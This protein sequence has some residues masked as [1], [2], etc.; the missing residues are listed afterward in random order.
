MGD[1][2][3]TS[4]QFTIATP[5]R[6]ALPKL[7]RCIGSVRGQ[8]E[9][10]YEHLVQDACSDDG[11]SGWLAAEEGGPLSFRSESDTGMYDAINRAWSRS[12]GD[13]LAWL[14]ADE[15]Y[16]PGT[17][18]RVNA[19]FVAHPAVD[20]V[21][22]NY[23]VAGES[24]RPVALRREVPFRRCYVANSFLYAQSC[25]LFFRRRAFDRI[26]LRLDTR[27][28]YASDMDLLLRLADDGAVIHHIP[29]YLSVFG[30]DG[31]N[32]ST[33]PQAAAE[34]EAIRRLHGGAR[35]QA[36]RSL[37]L[38][39]RRVERFVA[40]SYRRE[41]IQFNFA[42]NE[43]PQYTTIEADALGGRYAQSDFEHASP[44]VGAPAGFTSPRNE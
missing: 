9:A 3:M 19:Y 17:L 16:L 27:Y 5:T 15:Q 7:R 32:L 43:V 30:I 26:G 44:A 2:A 1:L 36:V 25:T 28:R 23:I 10:S 37:F 22:G 33:H 12:R 39:A 14:N 21:F 35:S 20:V 29:A 6:N 40:G 31:S 18:A 38:A 24:G 42:T 4:P 13:Y 8:T 34:A 11:T 41:A